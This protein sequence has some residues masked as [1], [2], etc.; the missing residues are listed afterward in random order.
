[1]RTEAGC[2][3]T[4]LGRI[5]TDADLKPH[6]FLWNGDIAPEA[7]DRWA[8]DHD[9][10]LPSDL[11]ALWCATG[12]GEM[13]ESEVILMPFGNPSPDNVLH[14]SDADVVGRNAWYTEAG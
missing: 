6:L 7:L 12:G 11:R 3:L 5:M 1:M 10:P 8:R 14:I 2:D 4:G 9:W 13:F